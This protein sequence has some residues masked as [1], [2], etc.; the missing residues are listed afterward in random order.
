MSGRSAAVLPRVLQASR[1]VARVFERQREWADAA[2]RDG[3]F[4]RAPS[5]P[6][7]Q[8]ARTRSSPRPSR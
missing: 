8:R 2:L 4:E 5:A 1:F 6:T 7:M 3:H